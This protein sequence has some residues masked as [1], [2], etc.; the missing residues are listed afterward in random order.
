MSRHVHVNHERRRI[1]ATLTGEVTD[2]TLLDQETAI[3][4]MPEFTAGYNI[5]HNWSDISDFRVT[6][7]GLYELVQHTID[8]SNTVAIV[9]APGFVYGMARMY[10]IM[11]NWRFERVGVFLD[12]AA[13]L[14]WLDA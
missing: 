10:A 14:S 1:T 9:A 6:G 8:D 7:S 11:A 2:A 4:A 12:G 5:L 13:A 3:R